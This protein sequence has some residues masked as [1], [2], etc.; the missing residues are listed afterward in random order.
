MQ[1]IPLILFLILLGA[2]CG[3]SDAAS[4]PEEWVWDIPDTVPLPRIP[5]DNPMTPAKVE[6]GRFL[7]YDKQLFG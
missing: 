2:G 6:L 4:A 3:S 5:E 1:T 7:F